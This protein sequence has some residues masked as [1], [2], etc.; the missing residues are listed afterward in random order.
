M[1]I[2]LNSIVRIGTAAAAF[3]ALMVAA[4]PG[5]AGVTS[6]ARTD[7]AGYGKLEMPVL[8]M[9]GPACRWM[10]K[11][12]GQKVSNLTTVNLEGTGHFVQEERPELVARTMVDFLQ[13]IGPAT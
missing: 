13:T 12:I 7:A 6:K 2:S 4:S 10:Q 9:G 8:A 3:A 1:E 11:V 5:Y